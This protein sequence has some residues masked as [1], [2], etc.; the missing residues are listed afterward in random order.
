[1]VDWGG[2]G[3]GTATDKMND[4]VTWLE[5]EHPEL[6]SFSARNW[7][8][9]GTYPQLLIVEHWTFL[10]EDWEMRVCYHVMI[11][12]YDWSKILLRRRGEWEPLLAVHRETDGTIYEIPVEEYP[13]M[14]Y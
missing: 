8:V 12:P 6:G 9:Y 3:K 2:G 10:D 4:F 7:F 11:P 5:T 13:I 14:G 1:V